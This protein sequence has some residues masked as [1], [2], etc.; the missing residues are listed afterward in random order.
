M[1]IDL[2]QQIRDPDTG[3]DGVHR[4]FQADGFRRHVCL[5]RG[6]P[7]SPFFQAHTVKFV[8]FQLAFDRR[9][10]PVQNMAVIFK[11]GMD[12]C[13]KAQFFQLILG[14]FASDQVT[15]K[16]L[17][18]L[19]AFHPYIPC[20][21][22][23]S[24]RRNHG[25]FI[26]PTFGTTAFDNQLWPVFGWKWHRHVVGKLAFAGCIVLFEK[27][28]GLLQITSGF[29]H[30]ERKRI[31]KSGRELSHVSI[32]FRSQLQGVTHGQLAK[33]GNLIAMLQ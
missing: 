29:R 12:I 16:A 20:A 18:I 28:D 17:I 8:S 23:I 7:Q 5:K 26:N 14:R 4:T 32:T 3:H 2:P 13:L 30:A 21:Q 33:G 11:P 10:P 22:P 31:K 24:Q 1:C 25:G 27:S 6:D 19:T 9:Q 15:V